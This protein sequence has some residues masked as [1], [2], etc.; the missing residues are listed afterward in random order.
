MGTV[1]ANC[2]GSCE[3]LFPLKG[4][5]SISQLWTRRKTVKTQIHSVS[6]LGSVPTAYVLRR[7]LTR[8]VHRP[9]WEVLRATMHLLS[10]FTE[11]THE[12]AGGITGG[13]GVTTWPLEQEIR[14]QNMPNPE[15]YPVLLEAA[16]LLSVSYR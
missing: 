16:S 6:Q 2:E 1:T 8:R 13:S 3:I 5:H 12:N 9:V 15:V 11:V 4:E 10:R 7:E 14:Q